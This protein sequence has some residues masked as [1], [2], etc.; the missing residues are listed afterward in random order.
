M[1]TT[2]I[3][4]GYLSRRDLAHQLGK[5]TRTLDRWAALRTGPPRTLMGQTILYRVDDVRRWLAAQREDRPQRRR[6]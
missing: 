2:E 6:A 4:D 5:S 1:T 3:L